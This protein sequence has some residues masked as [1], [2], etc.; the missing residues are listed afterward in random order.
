MKT[1]TDYW[2]FTAVCQFFQMFDSF[3]LDLTSISTK[4]ESEL[5]S[6]TEWIIALF[7]KLFK[8]FV[9]TRNTRIH[10]SNLL[11]YCSGRVVNFRQ[12]GVKG[13]GI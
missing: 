3:G 13:E 2:H 5:A 9:K 1:A 11:S 12:E 6:P 10:H 4:L 8:H 7:L